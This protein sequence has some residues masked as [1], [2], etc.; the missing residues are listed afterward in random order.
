MENKSIQKNTGCGKIAYLILAALS[1]TEFLIFYIPELYKYS[2]PEWVLYLSLFL[3]MAL[4]AVI[5]TLSAFLL[6][7]FYRKAKTG[8]RI[9][10]AILLTL[11]RLIYLLPYNYL[12]YA[13]MGYDL[14][15]SL[16]FASVKALFFLL[17][18]SLEIML[19]ALIAERIYKRGIKK[20]SVKCSLFDEGQIFDLTIPAHASLFA[21]SFSRF[22][23]DFITELINLINYVIEYADSYRLGEIYFIIGK[24]LFILLVLFL[25]YFILIFAKKK[26]K[27]HIS[28]SA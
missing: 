25:T 27:T 18:Y 3:R 10:K 13:T 15:E 16:I 1:L 9:L 24:F 28:A 19:F 8:K 14:F 12:Y 11:P 26:L 7:Y 22:A 20:L 21:I 5:P 2:L 23:L 6:F 4:F 17:V